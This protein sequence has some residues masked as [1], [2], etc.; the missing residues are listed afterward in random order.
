MKRSGVEIAIELY[1]VA[2]AMLR[3]RLAREH[4]QWSHHAINAEVNR[5]RV[6]RPGAEHGD[7]PGRLV[8]WPRKSR[9]RAR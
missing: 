1:A 8:A 5:W 9:S 7:S 4:P 3:Q 2:E 6:A